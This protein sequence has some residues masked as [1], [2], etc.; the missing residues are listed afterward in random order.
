[1]KNKLPSFITEDNKNKLFSLGYN[2]WVMSHM[3]Y[4]EYQKIL[5]GDMSFSDY[6]K[7]LAKRL[8]FEQV[9][10][11]FELLGRDYSKYENK[12]T[13]NDINIICNKSIINNINL[14]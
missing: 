1:M 2:E 7:N 10:P 12:K 14:N 13:K 11:I 8:T 9:K 6:I 5:M 3:N 4:D